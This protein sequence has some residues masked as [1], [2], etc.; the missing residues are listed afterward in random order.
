MV[1]ICT[2]LYGL[3]AKDCSP[4]IHKIN[5]SFQQFF[6]NSVVMNVGHIRTAVIQPP[7]DI[8]LSRF[9]RMNEINSAGDDT[10][11]SRMQKR[12]TLPRSKPS[13]S[14]LST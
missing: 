6:H 9:V 12:T 14:N 10:Q 3:N 4:Q 1:H 5:Q 11:K 13:V 7:Q 2:A 8:D